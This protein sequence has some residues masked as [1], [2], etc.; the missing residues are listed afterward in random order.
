P[1]AQPKPNGE[2]R[3]LQAAERLENIYQSLLAGIEASD[4]HLTV[5]GIADDVT[6]TPPDADPASEM[7]IFSLISDPVFTLDSVPDLGALPHT[8]SSTN[9][10]DTVTLPSSPSRSNGILNFKRDC[11]FFISGGQESDFEVDETGNG[12]IS[13]VVE[14]RDIDPYVRA[15]HKQSPTVNN[16]DRKEV[17]GKQ[18][19]VGKEAWPV[20]QWDRPNDN[21]CQP[22][23]LA[24]KDEQGE[25]TR[26]NDK[27][28]E[29]GPHD[30]VD[31]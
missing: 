14:W 13:L 28:R 21:A 20:V 10:G 16:S 29:Q 15:R 25:K 8:N 26:S 18:R 17:A 4:S 1:V 23:S 30:E 27:E 22:V 31:G 11:C 9:L 2:E 6:T 5:D 7:P 19:L 3:L 24:E 12:K